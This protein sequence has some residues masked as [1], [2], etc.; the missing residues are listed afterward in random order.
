MGADAEGG[1]AVFK[2][3]SNLTFGLVI[4]SALALRAALVL[5]DQLVMANI[6][7]LPKVLEMLPMDSHRRALCIA[8]TSA[9]AIAAADARSVG[10]RGRPFLLIARRCW[11]LLAD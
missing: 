9:S 11:R 1:T 5:H 4:G 8:L 2:F 10:L 3:A 7:L 6:N